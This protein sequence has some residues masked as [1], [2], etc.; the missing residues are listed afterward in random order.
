MNI[1]AI[2]LLIALAP[3][4]PDLIKDVESEFA[5]LQ[6]GGTLTDKAK[7]S[8]DTLSAIIKLVEGAL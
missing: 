7:A 2:R 5:T 6:G 3:L 8:L 4:V 1:T